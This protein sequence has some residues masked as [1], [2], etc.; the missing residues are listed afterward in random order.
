MVCLLILGSM[1][2]MLTPTRVGRTGESE[3]V[4][5]KISVFGRKAINC[6]GIQGCAARAISET[7]AVG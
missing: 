5:Q 7:F 3:G 6:R 1:L 2:F 4:H